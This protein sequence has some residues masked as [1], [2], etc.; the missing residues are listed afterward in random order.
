MWAGVTKG[1]ELELQ[2]R[3]SGRPGAKGQEIPVLH[4]DE[5]GVGQP[6]LEAD[7][8]AIYLGVGRMA[9]E[10]DERCREHD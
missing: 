5:L 2:V 6:L 8:Q 7:L 1:D 9:Q 3:H 4:D 10:H